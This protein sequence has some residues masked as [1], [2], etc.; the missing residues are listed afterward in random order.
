MLR[1]YTRKAYLTRRAHAN[2]AEF[3]DQARHL[4]NESLAERRDAWEEERRSVTCFDQYAKLTKRREAPSM[5]PFPCQDAAFYT[6][7]S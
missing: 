2:L 7:T 6:Q 1:T 5:E 3:L 4:Y